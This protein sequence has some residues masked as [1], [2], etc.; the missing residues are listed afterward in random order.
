MSGRVFFLADTGWYRSYIWYPRP[1]SNRHS[2]R[3]Y[4]LNIACLPI[5]PLGQ[6]LT[7]FAPLFLE[8]RSLLAQLDFVLQVQR[9]H[10]NLQAHLQQAL[11]VRQQVQ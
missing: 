2:L 1:D 6:T 10:L 8:H 7:Y 9:V 11:I 5:P 3:H 4:D